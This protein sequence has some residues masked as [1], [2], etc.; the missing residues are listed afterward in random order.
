MPNVFMSPSLFFLLAIRFVDRDMLMRY[1]WG[2]GI[3][4]K[5]SWDGPLAGASHYPTSNDPT[6]LRDTESH[7]DRQE[8]LLGDDGPQLEGEISA[9][10]NLPVHSELDDDG[11]EAL[12]NPLDEDDL[13]SESGTTDLDE[14]E[15]GENEDLGDDSGS[16][17]QDESGSG[18]EES[19]Y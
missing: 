14:M 6:L 12:E 17:Y 8:V 16:E 4:H 19:D 10:F 2:L 11:Q 3:G 15:D 1:H 18:S 9:D 5:Y 13:R 7:G